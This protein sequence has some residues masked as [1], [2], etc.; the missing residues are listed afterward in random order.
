MDLNPEERCLRKIKPPPLFVFDPTLDG[1]VLLGQSQMTDVSY[2]HR[3]LHLEVNELKRLV[4]CFEIKGRPQL[5]MVG[6]DCSECLHHQLNMHRRFDII[7]KDVV[8]DGRFLMEHRVIDHP[9]LKRCERPR[10]FDL[11]TKLFPVGFVDEL[12]GLDDFFRPL[13]RQRQLFRKL[14]NG[15]IRKDLMD[16]HL[17]PHFPQLRSHS[18][19]QNRISTQSEEVRF[20]TD[21]LLAQHVLPDLK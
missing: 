5:R 21:L 14:T 18:Y 4:K 7:G 11:S 16:L 2:F 12:E 19:A 9:R 20:D 6:N 3:R 8:I 13:P 15:R 17:I 10:I 1:F